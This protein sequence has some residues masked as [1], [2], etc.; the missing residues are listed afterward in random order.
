M[1]RLDMVDEVGENFM[2]ADQ[3]QHHH[4]G[5][6]SILEHERRVTF[7][8]VFLLISTKKIKNLSMTT[9]NMMLVGTFDVYQLERYSQ[10]RL[11]SCRHQKL[12]HPFVQYDL[13]NCERNLTGLILN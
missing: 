1:Q 7:L 4:E 2:E 6:F 11:L 5:L 12:V 9:T 13:K 8:S 3:V 10:P